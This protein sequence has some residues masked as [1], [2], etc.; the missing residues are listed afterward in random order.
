MVPCME[1][2]IAISR[3]K[4]GNL[5]GLEVLVEHYQVQAVRAAYLILYNPELAEDVAQAAFVKVVE[6]VHQFD[7]QRPFAPWFFRIVI[8]DALKL[9]RKQKLDISLDE[10]PDEL[11]VQLARWLSDPGASPEQLLERGRR[12]LVSTFWLPSKVCRSSNAPWL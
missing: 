3:I 6:R 11:T 4:Q 10:Q 12:K 8:D 7:V 5:I 1:D 9:A 2:Q